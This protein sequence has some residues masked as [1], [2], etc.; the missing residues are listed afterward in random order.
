MPILQH[1][2]SLLVTLACVALVGCGRGARNADREAP[3]S[4]PPTTSA[5]VPAGANALVGSWNLVS[6]PETDLSGPGLRMTLAIDSV[7][8]E[9]IHGRVTWYSAGDLPTA[10][11]RFRP[12]IGETI[13]DSAVH[14]HTALTDDGAAT[15][16]F[17][18]DLRKDTISLRLFAIGTDTLSGEWVLVRR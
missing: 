8:G 7:S 9:R 1:M 5:H 16:H 12:L 3:S 10:P 15:F 18:G 2:R 14:M 4:G 11:D 6:R 17:V 13:G